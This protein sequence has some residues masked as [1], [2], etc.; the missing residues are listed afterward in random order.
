MWEWRY[1][2]THLLTSA[3]DGDA[4]LASRPDTHWRGDWVD[5]RVGLGIFSKRKIMITNYNNYL[6]TNSKAPKT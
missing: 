4:W 2:S 3:I 6:A 5:P 1:S